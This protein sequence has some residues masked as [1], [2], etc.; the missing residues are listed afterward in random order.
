MRDALVVPALAATG[1]GEVV[2]SG[3]PVTAGAFWPVDCEV[4]PAKSTDIAT[5]TT[6]AMLMHEY[7]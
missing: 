6:I 2:R 7:L 4:H 5:S 3:V 1:A